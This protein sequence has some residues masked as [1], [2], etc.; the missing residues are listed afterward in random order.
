MLFENIKMS[1]RNIIH[2]KMRSFLTVLGV[3]IGV[4]SIVA[5]ISI[6]QGVTG[7]ITSQVA[8]MGSNKVSINV[9]GTPLKRGL[10]I[11][12]IDE[13]SAIDNVKGVSPNI[14]GKATISYNTEI[15]ENVSLQGKNQVHFKNTEDLIESGRGINKLDVDNKNRVCL[16]GNEIKD[17]FFKTSNP[18]GKKI[19]VNG[20][21][22]IIVGTL[23][24]SDGFSMENNNKSIVIPYTTAMSLLGVGSFSSLDV[25]LAN[26]DFANET[27]NKIEAALLSSFNNRDEGYMVTNMQ[28]ILDTI[29]TMT[30]T[31]TLMLGGIASIA[32]LVGGIGIMNMMLVT[33]TER[34]TEIGLRKALGA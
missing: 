4:A 6:V 17:E 2:N 32:L 34:T 24:P 26:S 8:E 7:S 1:W 20:A 28:N 19:I 30:N 23:Q 18:I 3:L 11:N 21:T 15:L 10:S 29:S 31:M 33:V 14:S 27:T 13:V 9:T 25:Y 16:I 22:Y 5:L 12:D